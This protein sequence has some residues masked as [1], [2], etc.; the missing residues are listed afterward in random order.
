MP[1]ASP[2][3]YVWLFVGR[4]PSPAAFRL[5]EYDSENQK[6]ADLYRLQMPT[7]SKPKAAGEGARPARNATYFKTNNAFTC[8]VTETVCGVNSSVGAGAAPA[9]FIFIMAPTIGIGRTF[10]NVSTDA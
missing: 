1:P 8:A 10:S 4:A 3:N 7:T 2:N 6:V 5:S 9:T